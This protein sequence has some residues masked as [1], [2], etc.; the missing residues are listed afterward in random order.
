M[1]GYLDPELMATWIM[2]LILGMEE[3]KPYTDTYISDTEWIRE[4]DPFITESE[5]YV[6]HR[7]YND[8][9]VTVLEGSGWQFQV[10]NELPVLINK[11]DE[12]FI[13]K[14]V[15]HRLIPGTTNLKIKIIES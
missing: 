6:W 14:L 2:D 5:E 9:T 11:G 8:R 10:D 15:Y 7:D 3:R 1:V 4:F 13:P 12:I